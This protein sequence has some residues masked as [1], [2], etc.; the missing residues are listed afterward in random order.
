MFVD[1]VS[2]S[3]FITSGNQFKQLADAKAA[4]FFKAYITNWLCAKKW[5]KAPKKKWVTHQPHKG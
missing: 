5:T 4:A 1:Y 3:S 2:E